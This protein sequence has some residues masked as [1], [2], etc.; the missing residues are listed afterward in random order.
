M[1][2]FSSANPFLWTLAGSAPVRE[3]GVRGGRGDY[4]GRQPLCIL[5]VVSVLSSFFLPRPRHH[6]RAPLWLH[7]E[8]LWVKLM[9]L[10]FGSTPK[11]SGDCC[12]YL[13]AFCSGWCAADSD[14]WLKL[15]RNKHIL[16]PGCVLLLYLTAKR[17]NRLDSNRP[18]LRFCWTWLIWCIVPDLFFLTPSFRQMSVRGQ[19]LSAAGCVLFKT[20]REMQGQR[21]QHLVSFNCHLHSRLIIFFF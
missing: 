9:M 6:L 7:W 13:S 2:L 4:H 12:H 5:L 11:H 3:L 10:I 16:S 1:A 18:G 14:V 19:R 8:V 20:N 15:K 17:K 21:L